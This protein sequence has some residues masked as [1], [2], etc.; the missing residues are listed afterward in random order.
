MVVKHRTYE[1]GPQ[2]SSPSVG[3]A[4]SVVFGSR[5]RLEKERESKIVK[6]DYTRVALDVMS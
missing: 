4:P 6:T 5:E 1:K 2:S 3:D